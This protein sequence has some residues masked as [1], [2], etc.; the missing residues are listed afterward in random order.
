MKVVVQVVNNGSVKINEKEVSKIK[1]GYVLF[2][3]FTYGDNLEKVYKI[4][5]KITKLRLFPDEEGK[6][7]LDIFAVNG[8]IL[9]VS[10]F[11]L[12]ANVVKGNRPSFTDAL[13]PVES[14]KLYDA[15]N[16]QLRELVLCVQTGVFGADMKVN[17]ENSGPFTIIID[18]EDF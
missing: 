8:E 18:S 15:F 11:T 3:G 13:D 1:K 16:N 7:N 6:T 4:A 9:S 2:V 14:E 10:Q 5:T 12:Y 17:L